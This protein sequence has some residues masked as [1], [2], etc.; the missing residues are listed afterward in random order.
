[1]KI[2]IELWSRP[3]KKKHKKHLN[4]LIDLATLVMVAED[5]EITK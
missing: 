1:M 4:V 5:K 2:Q 3:N